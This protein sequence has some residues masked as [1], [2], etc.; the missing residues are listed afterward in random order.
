[1][2]PARHRRLAGSK[3]LESI[4]K[5]DEKDILWDSIAM[6]ATAETLALLFIK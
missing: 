6:L 5:A 1:M 2:Q 4:Q 3:Q